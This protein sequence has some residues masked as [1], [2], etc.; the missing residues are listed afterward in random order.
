MDL[1]GVIRKCGD[2]T[3]GEIPFS[4]VD[5]LVFSALSYLDFT[6]VVSGAGFSLP[7]SALSGRGG[8]LARDSAHP[9]QLGLLLEECAASGRYSAVRVGYFRELVND[10][11]PMRFA[12][13]SFL[14]PDGRIYAAFRGTDVYLA[15]WHEDLDLLF[16]CEIPSQ[17]EAARYL[18]EVMEREPGEFF[19]GG[20][21]KGG[22]LAVFAAAALPERSQA[23]L[24]TIYDHDGPG[25]HESFFEQAGYL[26]ICGR[27]EK[28]VPHDSLI[29]MLLSHTK[30]F[31]IV[32]SRKR[33]LGQHNAFSW[34][35]ADLSSFKTLPST[36]R[37][38]R[39]AEAALARFVSGMS[40]S[41]RKKFVSALFTVIGAGGAKKIFDLKKRRLRLYLKMYRAY[42]ALPE[43]ERQLVKRGGKLL[44]K[45]VFRVIRKLPPQGKNPL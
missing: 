22:N 13:V 41:D 44:L 3:F 42:R 1:L 8:C 39:K 21:S 18:C 9:K 11:L 17:I 2:L 23:R 34:D 4:E 7:L 26:R 15:A 40:V 14:L 27:V 30:K 6:G 43:R 28:S 25:F 45:I 20:H 16:E 10:R 36:A 35:M 5:S 32:K 37:I 19:V 12:A 29:G 24:E 33:L 31:K 38:S